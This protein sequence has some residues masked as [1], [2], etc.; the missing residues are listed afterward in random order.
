MCWDRKAYSVIV[1]GAISVPLHGNG[2]GG[3][4]VEA[5]V[6]CGR[7]LNASVR[8]HMDLLEKIEHAISMLF[9]PFFYPSSVPGN[10]LFPE[11]GTNPYWGSY[12]FP[13]FGVDR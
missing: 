10:L 2:Q 7:E 6:S 9:Q 12:L 8:T 5:K 3:G 11:F 13:K 4:V 1:P